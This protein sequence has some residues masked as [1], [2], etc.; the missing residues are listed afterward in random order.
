M[1]FHMVLK[2]KPLEWYIIVGWTN[3]SYKVS[4]KGK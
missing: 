3:E 4:I 2:E 1:S